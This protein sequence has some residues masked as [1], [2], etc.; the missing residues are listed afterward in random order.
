MAPFAGFGQGGGL[1][2]FPDLGSLSGAEQPSAEEAGED[3]QDR[4]S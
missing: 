3:G 2:G 1:A 4:E